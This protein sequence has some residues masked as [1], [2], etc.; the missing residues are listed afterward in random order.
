VAAPAL[1]PLT[2]GAD[3]TQGDVDVY[4]AW[5][6]NLSRSEVGTALATWTNR[7]QGAAS[8]GKSYWE[9]AQM[10]AAVQFEAQLATM[11]IRNR[12]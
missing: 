10:G 8:E 3:V 7:A 6:T 9:T 12:R 5:R 4:S 11:W 2:A 1:P